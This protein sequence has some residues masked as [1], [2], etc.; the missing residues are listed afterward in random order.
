MHWLFENRAQSA[1]MLLE[2]MS[3]MGWRLRM[4]VVG[5]AALAVAHAGC[6]R[7]DACLGGSSESPERYQDCQELCEQGD[8]DACDRRSELEAK[9]S[10]ACSRR[11]NKAACRAMCHGRLNNPQAC[12]K[13]RAL[14]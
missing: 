3:R 12:Q 13:L 4:A 14:P 2:R 6:A 5:T 7:A 8:R 1:S 11:S 10:M 9:L